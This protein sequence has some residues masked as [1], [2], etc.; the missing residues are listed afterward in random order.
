MY[1]SKS[2]DALFKDLN[3]EEEAAYRQWARENY[4][5]YESIKGVWHP[6]VQ[7][8]CTKINEGR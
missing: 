7:N 6:V 5:K 4:T 8:E 3:D 2:T 1:K